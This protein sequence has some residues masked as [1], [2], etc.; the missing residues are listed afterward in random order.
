MRGSCLCSRVKYRISG[1]PRSIVGCH[2]N[3]CRK[4]SGHYVAATQVLK[5]FV[6]LQGIENVTWFQSSETAERGFCKTCG[7]Q[8]F[9]RR[10]GSDYVSVMAGTIDGNTGLKMD[11]QLYPETKGD[12]YQL[13]EGELVDQSSLQDQ[14]PDT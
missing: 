9:W 5:S 6:E 2:C 11:R 13:P 8:L 12:Y 7:S 1:S 10:H 14:S 3:Q 4:A